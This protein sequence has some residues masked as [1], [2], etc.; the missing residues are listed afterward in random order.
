VNEHEPAIQGQV[1]RQAIDRKNPYQQAG[2]RYRTFEDWERNELI[3]NLV[4]LLKQCNKDIQER[5]V[6]HLTQCDADY[7]R[8]VAEGIGIAMPQAS[9]VE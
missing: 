4:D 3:N 9:L 7:G 1:R 5:M 8:R 2:E 6:H